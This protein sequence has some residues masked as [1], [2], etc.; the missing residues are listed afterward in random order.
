MREPQQ[1]IG[2]AVARRLEILLQPPASFHHD[3]D[4][5]QLAHPPAELLR[6]LGHREAG[7]LL[8]EQLDDVDRL[9]EGGRGIVAPGRRAG[10]TLFGTW[11]VGPE[12]THD[13][14]GNRAMGAI[15]PAGPLYIYGSG[16]P[17]APGALIRCRGDGG[18]PIAAAIPTGRETRR[19]EVAGDAQADAPRPR[20]DD[21]R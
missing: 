15:P 5:E 3:D 14:G 11:H 13:V 2:D 9:L 10:R 6:D 12:I 1:V 17:D 18:D 21:L 8:G 7:F 19:S 16:T 20:I 4:P